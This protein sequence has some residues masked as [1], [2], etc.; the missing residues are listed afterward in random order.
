MNRISLKF[1]SGIVLAAALPL[2]GFG[3]SPSA[4]KK[5]DPSTAVDLFKAIDK[6]DIEVTLIPKDAVEGMITVANKT[7]KPLTI[8]MP[9]AF[10][11]VPVL[12]QLGGGL[13][14]GGGLGGGGNNNGGGN[15]NQGVGGGMMGGMGGMMGGMGGGMG[16]GMFSI[17]AEKAVKGKVGF[18]CL[19]HGL[20]D[21]N[22]RIPYKIAPIE[23]YA[24]APEV[25]ELVKMMCNREIDQHS[26]QAAAWHVQNG[27]SWE[28]LARKIGAKHIGGATE[29][30]F[31][32]AQL[33]RA[34]AAC[35]MAEERAEQAAKEKEKSPSRS[36]GESEN[37][38]LVRQ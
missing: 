11:G 29:P 16:G 37:Q 4:A 34:L 6:G 19:D 26:A 15:A 31:T 1:V 33:Q 23:S 7:G 21:P 30:Y 27:L 38:G 5:V 17:P 9:E 14:G 10:A 32:P 36:P 25:A 13:A 2:I 8:K 24:K 3:A 22:P 20:K 18:V 12:A 28:E 35:R